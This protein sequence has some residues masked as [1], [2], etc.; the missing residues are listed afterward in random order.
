[1]AVRFGNHVLCTLVL[2][3]IGCGLVAPMP[4][5]ELWEAAKIQ[6]SQRVLLAEEEDVPADT[7][8]TTL[9]PNAGWIFCKVDE[10]DTNGGCVNKGTEIIDAYFEAK[11]GSR[12]LLDEPI[13]EDSTTDPEMEHFRRSLMSLEEIVNIQ[14]AG[15]RR[16]LLQSQ[17]SNGLSQSE[18]YACTN[19]VRTAPEAFAG[20]YPC[21]T[22]FLGEYR[23]QRRGALASNSALNTAAQ[24]HSQDQS[25]VGRISHTGTDGSSPGQRATRAG[26]NWR[27]Y[28]ENVA[29]GQGSV[30][31]AVMAWMCSPGHRRNMMNCKFGDV[32][33]GVVGRYYTQLFGCQGSCGCSGSGSPTPFAGGSGGGSIPSPGGS[34]SGGGSIPSS[35]GFPSPGGGPSNGGSFPGFPSSGGSSGG[36]SPSPG[37]KPGCES[38]SSPF[39]NYFGRYFSR[40]YRSRSDCND[41]VSDSG[42]PEPFKDSGSSSSG[43]PS[44]FQG[45]GNGDF[46]DFFSSRIGGSPTPTPTPTPTP[47]RSDFFGRR[48][49]NPFSTSNS[50]SRSPFSFGGSSEPSPETTTSSPG[51]FG[52]MFGSSGGSSPGGSQNFFSSPSGP[53]GPSEGGNDFG[54]SSFGD[55]FGR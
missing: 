36:S 32:G 9:D 1:M 29:A 41:K 4:E 26:Y 24:R 20:D 54:F 16:K 51:G 11:V 47:S 14:D 30:K 46:S 8:A 42:S 44:P 37:P 38:N 49:S 39:A 18:L 28:G 45:S 34:S 6:L 13:K 35:G 23:S 5:E 31:A 55:F 22:S 19:A 15:L 17:C 50:D 3:L 10:V 21:G 53:S 2:C 33:V 12:K 40:Y 52:D 7:A 43:S 27:T 25:R 48:D